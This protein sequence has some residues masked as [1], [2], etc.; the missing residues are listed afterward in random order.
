MDQDKWFNVSMWFIAMNYVLGRFD[1]CY[2][3]VKM[4]VRIHDKYT[5]NLQH[6]YSD[7]FWGLKD[8]DIVKR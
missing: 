8:L 7:E 6:C 4:I 1:L 5:N 3:I 2:K